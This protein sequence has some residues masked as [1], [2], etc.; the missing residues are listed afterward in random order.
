MARQWP[1]TTPDSLA[2]ANILDDGIIEIR[3]GY[4]AML[5]HLQ[6]PDTH[7]AREVTTLT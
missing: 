3:A 1:P 2:P 6:N 4:V 5:L 7:Y